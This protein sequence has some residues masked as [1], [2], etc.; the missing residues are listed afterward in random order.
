MPPKTN[1]APKAK[2]KLSTKQLC[3][4]WAE[5]KAPIVHEQLQTALPGNRWR[6]S[7]SEISG[8]CPWHDD[9]SPSFRIYLNKGYCKCFGCGKYAWN[10]VE[11][12]AKVKN[13]PP[14]AAL[15]ELRTLFGISFLSASSSNQLA[16]WERNQLLK[17]RICE[18]A[19]QELVDA[20]AQPTNPRY[21]A[22][23]PA[24]KWLLEDR[25]LSRDA[26]HAI[27]IVGIVPPVAEVMKALDAEGELINARLLEEAEITAAETGEKKKH[28]T[29]FAS[30]ATDAQTYLS[31]AAGWVGCV[32]FRLD[33]APGVIGRLK[34]RRPYTHDVIIHLDDAFEEEAGFFGLGWKPYESLLG[35]AQ[36]YVWPYLVEGEFDALTPMVH[37]ILAGGPTFV[38][39]ASSGSGTKGYLDNLAS[40]GFEEIYLVGDSPAGNGEK[41]IEAWLPHITALRAK[42][43]DGWD[44]FPGAKDPDEAVIRHTFPVFQQ[45][46]LD[47]QN[48]D[49]FKTPQEWAFER[50]TAE[51]DDIPVEDIQL[52]VIKAA[53]WGQLLKNPAEQTAYI[54]KCVST[55]ALPE[56]ILKREII[57]SGEDE[58][59]FIVRVAG[60]LE[61]QFFV[62]GQQSRDCDRRLYLWHR[63]KKFTIQISLA[64]D[65]SIEREIGATLGPA[66]QFFG[67]KIGIPKFMDPAVKPAKYL[68]KLDLD[69]RW[70]YRQ[71]LTM[72][73]QDTPNFDIARHMGQGI[74]VVPGTKGESPTVYLV[75]GC[76]IYLGTYDIHD[77][78]TWKKLDG[79]AHNGIIFDVGITRNEQPWLTTVNCV[80]D[81]EEATKYDIVKLYHELAHI[82]DIGWR[83][84]NHAISVEYLAAHLLAATVCDA[85]RRKTFM[86]F[87][88][89]TNAGKSKLLMGLIAGVEST[90]IHLIAAAHGMQRFTAAAVRQATNNK[91]RPLCLDEF[92]DEGGNARADISVRETIGIFRSQVGDGDTKVIHG[93]RNGQPVEYDL[94]FFVFV[95][96]INKA[97]TPADANRILTLEMAKDDNHDNPRDILIR[98]IGTVRL[99]A[100]KHELAIA[101][102]PH[103]KR[104]QT[105]YEEVMTEYGQPN[106]RPPGIDDRYFSTLYPAIVTLKL[107]GLD[108][109][110]FAIR[111]CEANRENIQTVT[112]RTDSGSIEDWVLDSPVLSL[113]VGDSRER[114]ELSLRDILAT[115]ES[116]KELNSSGNGLYLDEESGVVYINW[117]AAVQTVMKN[118]PRFSRE[119]NFQNLRELANRAPHAM[120]P[121]EIVKSAGYQR[122]KE[123]V[124]KG[125]SP[126]NITAYSLAHLMGRAVAPTVVKP[127]EPK[128]PT[129]VDD[130]GNFDAA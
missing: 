66:Y 1:K 2:S 84:K 75:N 130:N 68:Q 47:V 113:R 124:L 64:D 46:L 44:R 125:I 8:L 54:N 9:T 77:V 110:Q 94:T 56:A 43:F 12:W 86:G 90:A 103:I 89:D 34:I 11:L 28:T 118:H 121:A 38:V 45:V 81:L 116:R 104:L 3:Q 59:A 16:A 18:L 26:I 21:A 100:M 93:T 48:T 85:Y 106:A 20:I 73:S 79:P 52:R 123:N 7:G 67:E 98:E 120:K 69:L 122:L 41:L 61:Q 10:P 88:A 60:A 32:L 33:L 126:S 4:I 30:L 91:S 15:N 27:D 115:H 92:E 6:L 58:A 111:F 114:K 35:H 24:V 31:Q 95:A 70:Y 96:A 72:L 50:A 108:Y 36:K 74:H 40:L 63:A 39:I 22:A 82:L 102:L 29:K 19:H 129:K 5:M 37:Q 109:H 105:V 57:A 101:M 51:I 99:T 14:S 97:Y 42:I 23:Q 13:C 62:I 127:A 25:Q 65:R 87:H 78:L 53:V 55:Y 117:I 112:T 71:A 83:F 119:S 107:L 76:D 17:R 128:A 49:L 80:K